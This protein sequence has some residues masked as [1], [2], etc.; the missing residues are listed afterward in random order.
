MYHRVWVILD[1]HI[2][3]DSVS[4]KHEAVIEVEAGHCRTKGALSQ[5]LHFILV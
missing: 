1:L 5:I 3:S 4:H 2:C